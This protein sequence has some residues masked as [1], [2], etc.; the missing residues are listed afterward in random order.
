MDFLESSKI[1]KAFI[2]QLAKKN[3]VVCIDLLGHG[4]TDCLGYIHSMELMAE[5]VEFV[6]KH[7][8]IRKSIFIGH[9]MGGYVALAFAEK[10]PDNVKGLCLLN[11]TAGADSPQKKKNRDR[12]ISAVKQN[13]KT[14]IRIAVANLFTPKKPKTLF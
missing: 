4:K 9:S 11:S 13:H 10:N 3:R 12:G 2:P 5:V 8:R 14:F 6:L 1:W 7:L